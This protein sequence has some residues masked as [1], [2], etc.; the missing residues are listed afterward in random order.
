MNNSVDEYFQYLYYLMYL[1]HYISVTEVLHF[2]L[3]YICLTAL[4]ILESQLLIKLSTCLIIKPVVPHTQT[5]VLWL[6]VTFQMSMIHQRDTQIHVVCVFNFSQ[7]SEFFF[8]H[9]RQQLSDMENVG[10]KKVR[11]LWLKVHYVDLGKKCQIF[12]G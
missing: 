2:L 11:K 12:I 9:C 7:G 4:I 5:V 8:H 10:H 3:H 6:V 1:L